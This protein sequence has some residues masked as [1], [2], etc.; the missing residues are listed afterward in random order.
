[1]LMGGVEKFH[2]SYANFLPQLVNIQGTFRDCYK[3][4]QRCKQEANIQVISLSIS[5]LLWFGM[6][7]KIEGRVQ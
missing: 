3:N 6:K 1:M 2:S 7:S 4:R 5:N